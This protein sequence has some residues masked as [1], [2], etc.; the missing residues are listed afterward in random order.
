MRIVLGRA[1]AVG[2]IVYLAILHLFA[3]LAVVKT[4]LVSKIAER[5]RLSHGAKQPNLIYDYSFATELALNN[6]FPKKTVYVIGDSI[7]RRLDI[8]R[9]AMKAVNLGISGDNTEGVLHRLPYFD[10]SHRASVL[11]LA[12]GVN[13]VRGRIPMEE[14]INNYQS[15]VTLCPAGLPL[16]ISAVLPVDERV[17]EFR[18]FNKQIRDFNE[19][20]RAISKSRD[21]TYFIDIG[22][23]ISDSKGNLA[24][25]YEE[26]DGIH[27]N[28]KALMIISGNLREAVQKVSG[29]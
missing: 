27:P 29:D 10:V 8:T 12:V 26:P 6:L 3:G 15:I 28:P 17:P 24:P 23:K 7:V 16:V 18:G 11:V 4:D 9:I 22:K 2:F 19:A 14:A 5:L 20:L 1:F 21:E 13:D 25:Q